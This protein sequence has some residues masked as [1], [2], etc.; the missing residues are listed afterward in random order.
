MQQDYFEARQGG[1]SAQGREGGQGQ[2]EEGLLVLGGFVLLFM[3]LQRLLD[4]SRRT[5][6]DIVIQFSIQID[7][8]GWHGRD[9]ATWPYKHC[10]SRTYIMQYICSG[11]TIFIY[12]HVLYIV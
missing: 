10:C 2:A 9:I 7:C 6:F 1:R 11:T 8:Y 4:D 3:F 12:M 5:L